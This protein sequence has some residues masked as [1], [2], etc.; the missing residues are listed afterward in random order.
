MTQHRWFPKIIVV[1][2][3]GIILGLY[4]Y[5]ISGWLIED[6]EGTA[7]YATWRFAEGET[8]YQDFISHKGPLFLFLG[9]GLI[10]IF[11][12][13]IWALRAVTALAV[14]GGGYLW[15]RGLRIFYGLSGGLIGAVIFLLTPEVYHLSRVFRPDSWMLAMVASALSLCLIGCKSKSWRWSFLAGVLFGLS[16]LMKIVAIMPFLGCALFLLLRILFTQHRKE[17]SLKLVAFTASAIPIIA[18]GFGIVELTMPGAW[19]MIIGSHGAETGSTLSWLGLSIS[20]TLM[21][22]ALFIAQNI[23]IIFALPFIRL[24]LSSQERT[25][26]GLLFICQLLATSAILFLGGV[27][28]PRYLAYTAISLSGLYAM[29]ISYILSS[30]T[31]RARYVAATG[32]VAFGIFLGFFQLNTFLFRSEI[33]TQTLATYIADN[34]DIDDVILTDYAELAF[35]AQRRSVP[36]TGGIGFGW[37]STGLITGEELIQAM[38]EHHVS[39]VALHVPDGPEP[40]PSHLFYL[41]D[42]DT[43]YHYVQENYQLSARVTRHDQLF[44]VYTTKKVP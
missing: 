40:P 29:G 33:G 15:F 11:G 42:W 6:D 14:I 7:L 2:V 37:T 1:L 41:H 25:K 10:K 16:V 36:Q 39:L 22:Y 38:Q 19:E 3:F 31:S 28:Y 32:I 8:P 18:L 12:A 34:T 13:N 4:L 30:N 44:E 9:A 24:A 23:I 43:F 35:H 17:A 5:N 20:K 27:V 21:I 26:L